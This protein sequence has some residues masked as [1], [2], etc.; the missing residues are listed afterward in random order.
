MK[1]AVFT[2]MVKGA[3]YATY[4][5]FVKFDVDIFIRVIL[6]SRE[7]SSIRLAIPAILLD[8]A[9]I[10]GWLVLLIG[11]YF[12]IKCLSLVLLFC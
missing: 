6:V 5:P 9:Y 8:G 3:N 11:A 10:K 1:G 4:L 7:V 12:K 2:S